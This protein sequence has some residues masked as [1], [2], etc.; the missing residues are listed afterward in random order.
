MVNVDA[1]I[2][3]IIAKIDHDRRCFKNNCLRNLSQTY[4]LDSGRIPKSSGIGCVRYFAAKYNDDPVMN[5]I[6]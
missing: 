5:T 6:G 2:T 1:A 4:F 3:L